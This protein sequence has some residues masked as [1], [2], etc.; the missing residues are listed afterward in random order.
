[1]KDHRMLK[2]KWLILRSLSAIHITDVLFLDP[3]GKKVDACDLL[4]GVHL[5]ERCGMS[6]PTK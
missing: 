5:E 4:L 2:P 6:I 3:T 1:M